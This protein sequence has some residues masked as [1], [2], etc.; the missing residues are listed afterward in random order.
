MKTIIAAIIAIT[1]AILIGCEEDTIV[2]CQAPTA[3]ELEAIV[4]GNSITLLEAVELF[5][6]DK[7]G[8]YPVNAD[9]DTT[10]TGKVL[11]DYLPGGERLLNPFTGLKDQ[12]VDSIP[13]SPG[14]ISYYKYEHYEYYF[15]IYFIKG[16]GTN[17][18]IVEYDNIEE[19]KAMIVEDCLELQRAVEA[20]RSERFDGTYPN[21]CIDSNDIGNTLVDYL[22]DGQFMRNRFTMWHTEPVDY[23]AATTGQI[24]YRSRVENGS[25]VGYTITAVGLENGVHIFTLSVNNN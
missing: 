19:T 24:G 12:P 17:S 2:E 5:A 21:D 13:S 16:Y 1:C 18:I 14:E 7:N 6:I 15:N 9:S 8:R 22:P 20:W 3:E 25:T 11:I 4:K 10:I 23:G